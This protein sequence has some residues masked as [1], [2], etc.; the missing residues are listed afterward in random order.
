MN[1]Q[2]PIPGLIA[3]FLGVAAVAAI[4]GALAGPAVGILFFVG[5]W[6]LM[7][8]GVATSAAVGAVDWLR[9]LIHKKH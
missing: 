1:N 3:V 8:V 7:A 4:M 6:A 2:N 9:D 5:F